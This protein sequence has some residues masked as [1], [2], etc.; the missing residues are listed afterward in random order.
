[1]CVIDLYW[2]G[3]F[4]GVV[5]GDDDGGD[6]YTVAGYH[7]AICLSAVLDSCFLEVNEVLIDLD[8]V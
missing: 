6:C 1:M 3:L 2:I 5:G 4:A 8:L 7:G